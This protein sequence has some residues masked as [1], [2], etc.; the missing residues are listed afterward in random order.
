MPILLIIRLIALQ[1]YITIRQQCIRVQ[2]VGSLGNVKVCLC[3]K[4]Y[5]EVDSKLDVLSLS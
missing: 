3:I 4:L 1:L 2:L 5:Y